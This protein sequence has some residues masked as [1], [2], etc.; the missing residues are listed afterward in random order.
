V[1]ANLATLS[2]V[3][4]KRHWIVN[5]LQT[6]NWKRSGD[7][8]WLACDLHSIKLQANRY[9][10]AKMRDAIEKSHGHANKLRIDGYVLSQLRTL[11]NTY[12]GK[13]ALTEDDKKPIQEQVDAILEYCTELAELNQ[14]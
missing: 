5:E 11:D 7:A 12:L 8:W 9:D 13:T 10:L 3:W 2:L 6:I 1:L 14:G 4:A